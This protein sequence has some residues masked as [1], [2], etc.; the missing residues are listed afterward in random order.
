MEYIVVASQCYSFLTQGA[1]DLDLDLDAL[2][3][4]DLDLDDEP[5][6]KGT[7]AFAPAPDN[8]APAPDCSELPWADAALVVQSSFKQPFV[9]PNQPCKQFKLAQL[10]SKSSLFYPFTVQRTAV[11]GGVRGLTLQGC[12]GRRTATMQPLRSA[13]A[14]VAICGLQ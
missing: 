11:R 10:L 4:P 1:M 3:L 12:T 2:D 9:N 6:G 14:G 5:A 13:A 8:A 7:P